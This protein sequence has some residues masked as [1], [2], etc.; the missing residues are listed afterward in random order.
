M[1]DDEGFTLVVGRRGAPRAAG[2]RG[3]TAAGGG[4]LQQ[5]EAGDGPD[6]VAPVRRCVVAMEEHGAHG[7]WFRRCVSVLLPA[8]APPW[9]RLVLLGLGRVR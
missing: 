7:T 5:G 1:D 6:A 8:G 3:R 9:G 2:R 4:P